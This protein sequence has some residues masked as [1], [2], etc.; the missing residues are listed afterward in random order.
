MSNKILRL[1]AF[2]ILFLG[3]ALLSSCATMS[4]DECMH[5]DWY[6][7][8]LEDATQGYPLNRIGEHSKACARTK[9]TP[10]MK[11]Y[12]DGHKKGARLYCLPEKGYSAGRDGSAYNGIC[13]ADLEN[14]FLRAYRD[15]Q[16]LFAIQRKINNLN[17][18][19]SSNQSRIEFLYNE[20]QALQYDIS[21]RINDSKERQY[22]L[23][24]ID[25]LHFQITD[26]EI[27][28]DRAAHELAVCRND[29]RLVEDKHY[30]MG[31]IN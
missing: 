17:N 15:G 3:S 22:K 28:T 31:Y 21:Q 19:I 26:L 27:R 12:E 25:D 5:A 1:C 6:I 7:K 8:G 14:S 20:I 16:E 13:P 9:I 10:V 4:K 30:R 24:R 18:E 11:D 29:Y 2:S 23:H